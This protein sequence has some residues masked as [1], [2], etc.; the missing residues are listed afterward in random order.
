MHIYTVVGDSSIHLQINHHRIKL[1]I[2]PFYDY[3]KTPT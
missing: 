3:L 2:R 1:K